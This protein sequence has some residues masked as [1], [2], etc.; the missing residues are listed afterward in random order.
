MLDTALDCFLL[1]R[2][3]AVHVLMV[4][5]DRVFRM[6]HNKK[7]IAKVLLEFPE[8]VLSVDLACRLGLPVEYAYLLELISDSKCSM[9]TKLEFLHTV[10]GRNMI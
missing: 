6:K 10:Y 3:A 8:S 5:S 2:P 9:K 7:K 4:L 1:F